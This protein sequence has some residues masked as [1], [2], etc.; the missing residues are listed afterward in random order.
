VFNKNAISTK[1][2]ARNAAMSIK[3]SKDS[4]Y[5]LESNKTLN[6]KLASFNRLPE[7]DDVIQM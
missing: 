1:E 4:D 7:Y 3:P 2:N 6:H 5:S